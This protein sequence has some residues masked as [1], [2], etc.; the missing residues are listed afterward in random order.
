MKQLSFYRPMNPALIMSLWLYLVALASLSTLIS[1]S[2]YDE[3]EVEWNLNI[4]QNAAS[5]LEYSTLWD[6]HTYTPSPK[7]WRMP[8]YSFFLDRFVNGDPSNDN[9]NGTAWEHDPTGTQL[10]HGGD[11]KGVVDSLDYLHGLGIR[12]IYL[13]GSIM[14]NLPWSS[15]GYSPRDHTILDHHFGTLQEVR[16]AIDAI[17]ARGMYV[18]ADNTMATMSDLFGFE[19]YYNSSAPWSFTEHRMNYISELRY[20]D[21]SHSNNFETECSIPYPRFWNLEGHLIDDNATR[22]MVGCMDS[23][24]DQYGDTGAFGIYPEWRKQL[25]KFGGVQDRLR[26]WKPSVLDKITHLSCLQI[27]GLD[28]DGF[29]MDKG[30]QVVVDSQ[31]NFSH[32]MRECAMSVGKTNFFIPGEIVNGNADGAIYIGR[33]KE[34]H[35]AY[36]SAMEAVTS[37]STSA[38]PSTDFVR[39]VGYQAV[40]AA[41]FHYTTYRAL[42]EYLGLDGQLTSPNDSPTNFQ[43]QWTSFTMTNDMSNAYT[44]EFDPRHMYGVSNQDV[45]RWPGFVN[46][47]QRQL[48]GD[49]IV[50]LLM[51]GIPLVSWGE[52]QAFYTLDNTANNYIYGRQSMSSSL[53]WQMHGCNRIGDAKIYQAPFNSSLTACQDDSVSLD[54]RDPSHPVYGV[55]KQMYEMRQRYPVL[56]DGW[57]VKEL[58]AQTWNWTQPGSDGVGTVTGLWSVLRSGMEEVQDFTGQGMFDNQSV[59]L[60]HSNYNG[61]ITYDSGCTNDKNGILSPFEPGTTVRNMFYPFDQWVVESLNSSTGCVSSMNMSMYGWKSFVPIEKWVAPSPLVTRFLP[62]HDAR[63]LSNTGVDEPSAIDVEVRFSHQMD[64]DSFES[65]VSVRSNT[66]S[67]KQAYLDTTTLDCLSIDPQ[68]EAHYAGPSPS[69]WRAKFSLKNAYDGVHVINVNNVTNQA[70]EAST[71]SND[72]FMLRIGQTENPIVFPRQANYSTTLLFLSKT[73]KRDT[74]ITDSGLY[75]THKAAGADKWRYSLS[76]GAVWSDWMPYVP[77]NSTLPSQTWTGTELQKWDGDHVKVQYW[78][79]ATGSSDHIVEGDLANSDKP[80]R[81]FPHLFIHGSFNQYG[82]SIS[83]R[84]HLSL[85]NIV[86]Y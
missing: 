22:A 80:T 32:A 81:R 20:R 63:I 36:T 38:D 56:N 65:G 11:M 83:T 64:C 9:A 14:I 4:N 79:L 72:K 39:E 30:M 10:R 84:I 67:G 73:S 57:V 23:D 75:I 58:S 16:D 43:E 29:R 77:G 76:W 49:F 70:S 61:S 44:G 82:E 18:I 35:M 62:G 37:N 26:D 5:P 47:T 69:I 42:T 2:W 46:G 13:V 19:G 3:T 45:F 68:F 17:H 59:W 27:Q 6:N 52:E 34:P 66:E 7:N 85:E 78:S 51:P 54:H 8:F 48:L 60:L 53:A 74:S 12:G 21:F 40:D 50:T 41:A 24:F 1:A 25:S 28:I 33:G 55:M 15:D 31:A 86:P 71:N